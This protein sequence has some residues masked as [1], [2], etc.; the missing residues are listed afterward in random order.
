GN[1]AQA[2]EVMKALKDTA[3]EGQDKTAE[4]LNLLAGLSKQLLEE[5][6]K[7]ND[8]NELQKTKAGLNELL[9]DAIKDQK[10][11]TEVKL[12]LAQ[13]YSSLDLH[14]KAADLLVTVEEPKGADDKA[15]REYRA[16]RILYLRELRLRAEEYSGLKQPDK[17]AEL[18][19][20][21][22]KVLE[23]IMGTPAKR[24]WGYTSM[25]AL[26]E[27]ILVREAQG[28]YFQSAQQ[29]NA[30]AQRMI[31]NLPPDGKPSE[32][33]FDVVYHAVYGA[34]KHAQQKLKDQPAKYAKSVKE[35]AKVVVGLENRYKGFGSE[36]M[37]KR[38]EE[39][40]ASEPDL[41]A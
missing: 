20:T 41:K 33:Y 13:V 34:V 38:F 36:A 23:E 25:S 16:A 31:K 29:A 22:E 12:A 35:A 3:E 11:N 4:T 30:L 27:L 2:R 24:G 26:K 7:K 9:N 1:L 32:E 28:N 15:L 39:L 37:K 5:V 6:K 21:A 40:L 17:A 19:G 14:G 18:I 8:P 10:L